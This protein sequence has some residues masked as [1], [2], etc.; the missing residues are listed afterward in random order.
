MTDLV[1]QL[2]RTTR[3]TGDVVAAVKPEQLG[4]P[5]PCS[6]WTVR[7]LL[8]HLVAVTKM[9]GTAATG[10]RST[11]N[12]FGAPDDVIGDDPQAAYDEARRQLMTAYRARGL[13]GTVPLLSGEAP[14]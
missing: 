3:T 11:I 5:T 2:D 4:D 14:A 1:D 7:D 6:E 9:F 13:D 10:E 8:N 12:P